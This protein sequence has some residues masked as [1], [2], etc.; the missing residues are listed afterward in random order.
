MFRR[1]SCWH[2]RLRGPRGSPAASRCTRLHPLANTASSSRRFWRL[3]RV[4]MCSR[5]DSHSAWVGRRL[6]RSSPHSLGSRRDFRRCLARCS[7]CA[8][9]MGRTVGRNGRRRCR[10][11]LVPSRRR[12]RTGIPTDSQRHRRASTP[13]LARLRCRSLSC[14]RCS[15]DKESRSH[16]VQSRRHSTGLGD[17]PRLDES[18]P[19]PGKR[20]TW[21]WC[22]EL[23]WEESGSTMRPYRPS[24][25]RR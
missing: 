12:S 21:R 3:W 13:S 7:R 6:R 9:C 1:S 10:A 19:F 4:D 17:C 25:S 11:R 18:R 23:W 16:Q 8:V 15:L 20:H 22:R 14:S 24:T 2:R 5:S